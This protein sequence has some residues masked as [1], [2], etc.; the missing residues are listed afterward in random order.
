[1]TILYIGDVMGEAGIEVVENVLPKLRKEKKIDF[2]VAQAE[3]VSEGKGIIVTDFKRLQKAGVDFFTGGNH[4]L[5][6]AESLQLFNDPAQPIIR[7]ANYIKGTP[8]F[9]YKYAKTSK[10]NVLVIS[11]LGKVVGRDA[12]KEVDNPLHI[13]DSILETEKDNS[14]IATVVNF[15][16]DF[17]SEKVVIGHYLD[18]RVT[19]VIG[20]HWHVPTADA[21]VLPGGTAHMTDVGMCG[22]LDSSLGVSY[23]AIITRWR[24][25]KQTKNILETKGPKQFNALLIESD[26][27]TG[28]ALSAIA[29]NSVLK[30]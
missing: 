2:A 6:K 23:D 22:A 9:G 21:R 3:N 29:I 27:A 16:G 10:G 8:G 14:K 20:D 1:M 28:K 17:S 11:L 26:G 30:N 5:V 12:D 4:S 19:A 18:G 7:P 25:G 15:H 13:V 24:D